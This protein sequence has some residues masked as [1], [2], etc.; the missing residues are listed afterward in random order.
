MVYLRASSIFERSTPMPKGISINIGLNSVDA[1]EYNGWGGKLNACE[2]DALSMA[3]LAKKAGFETKVILTEE[4]TSANV[5]A[6][7]SDASKQ[8]GSDDILFLTYSGHGGQL[9]D[10]NGEE[11]DGKDETWVLYDRQLVDDELYS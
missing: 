9:P 11:T 6:A 5:T 4:A 7:I 3:A 10:T 1:A 8:L 2:A